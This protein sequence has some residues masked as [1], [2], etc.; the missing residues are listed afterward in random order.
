MKIRKKGG[1]AAL[2]IAA[3]L[4]SS[5]APAAAAET[6]APTKARSTGTVAAT[7]AIQPMSSSPTGQ[8]EWICILT[9]GHSHSLANGEPLTNCKGSYL[10][11]YINGRHVATYRLAYGGGAV[12]YKAEGCL[13]AI[14]G[15]VLGVMS[16][17]LTIRWVLSTAVGGIGAYQACAA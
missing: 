5:A 4:L 12:D 3:L 2:A 1:L 15:G 9:S 8:Y 16:P 7:P 17:A 14:I 13:F 10:H 6:V 11:R